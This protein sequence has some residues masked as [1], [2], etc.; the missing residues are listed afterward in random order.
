LRLAVKYLVD[1]DV[2]GEAMKP[3]PNPKVIS[4]GLTNEPLLAVSPIVLG[5]VLAGILSL[6]RSNRRDLLVQWFK[7]EVRHLT[8]VDIDSQTAEIWAE[9]VVDL[10][11]KGKSMPVK[12][13]LIAASV[14]QH[15]LILV[16][17]NVG[18]YQY[19]GVN[20]FNPFA[21]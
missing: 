11:R 14:R 12:D 4:W 19:A 5:E 10:R 15:D 2:L 7:D 8:S 3:Y 6:P 18:D 17:R 16:T 13:S 21:S 1:T 9:L 20:L